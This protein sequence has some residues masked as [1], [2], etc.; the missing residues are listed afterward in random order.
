MFII[1]TNNPLWTFTASPVESLKKHRLASGADCKL[2]MCG[3]SS[4]GHTIADTEDRGLLS[5]CGF[6]LGAF[7]VIRNLALNL[8]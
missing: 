7:N 4:I 8:I 2:V 5:I 3:L 1:L 6:D